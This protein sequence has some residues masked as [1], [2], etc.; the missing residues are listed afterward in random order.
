MEEVIEK[1]YVTTD[2]VVFTVDKDALKVLLIKRKNPPFRGMFAIP[3]GFLRDKDK[4][5]DECAY[6]ELHE[7]TGV[8][9][10]FLKKLTAF[11][12]KGRDPRGRVITISYIALISSENIELKPATD[13]S[14]AGWFHINSLPT[15]AFDH[16]EILNHALSILKKELETTNIAFQLLPET[17]TLT[18]MQKV[19]EAAYLEKL[20][21]RNFRKKIKLLDILKD[22]HQT[23]MEGA[24][25]PAKLYSFK[26]KRYSLLSN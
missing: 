11:G 20:D 9:D 23:K 25:R 24:H 19:Y 7:E 17:F 10:I 14:D 18:E 8:R 4:T 6:R 5:L 21:K 15:L 26:N 3:G 22:M 1:F 2:S 16:K 12:D 13:A